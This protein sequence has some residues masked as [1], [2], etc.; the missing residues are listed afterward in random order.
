MVKEFR[1]GAVSWPW[2]AGPIWTIE[3]DGDLDSSVSG[4]AQ[5]GDDFHHLRA[6]LLCRAE[7]VLQDEDFIFGI[8]EE[9]LERLDDLS[10]LD[11]FDSHGGFLQRIGRFVRG[12]LGA[13]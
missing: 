5:G 7:L 3:E 6:G 8:P 4:G 13:V 2:A 11:K 12:L 10:V 9:R 1:E